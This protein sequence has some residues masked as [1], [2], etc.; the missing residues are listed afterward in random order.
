MSPR[1]D[2]YLSMCLEQ[3]SKSP[4][5]YR[6]GCIIVRG[7]KVIGQGYN[8]YRPGFNGGALKTGR[9]ASASSAHGF[10]ITELKQRKKS[11]TK[12]DPKSKNQE[13]TGT[14]TPFEEPA[15]GGGGHLANTP[16]S[17][18]SEMM[19]I[20][21]A[22][23]LSGTLASQGSARSARWLE[24]PYDYEALKPMS[25]LSVPIQ[26]S[27]RRPSNPGAPGSAKPSS[28][29]AR[30]A[31]KSRV[32]KP[33]HLNAVAKDKEEGNINEA[34]DKEKAREKGKRDEKAVL[35]LDSVEKYRVQ[36]AYGYHH[37]DQY[38]GRHHPHGQKAQPQQQAPKITENEMTC[39]KASIVSGTSASSSSDEGALER[40]PKKS[41]RAKI[42]KPA[43][44]TINHSAR[45]KDSLDRQHLKIAQT[46]LLPQG[47]TGSRSRSVIERT[48]DQRL[49]GADL[50]VARLGWKKDS[51]PPDATS[52]TKTQNNLNLTT[53][54]SP[55]TTPANSAPLPASPPPPTSTGSLHEEL[56][57]PPPTLSSPAPPKP[58]TTTTT[59][60]TTNT[61]H[62]LASISSSR[63]CYR[64]IAYMH[65]VG[66]KRVFWTNS[67]GEWDGGKV[68]D[69]VDALESGGPSAESD[70]CGT[71]GVAGNGVFVTKHEVLMLRRLMGG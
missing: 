16:L 14:F 21:S 17:M 23:S 43:A 34:N 59:T 53:G 62:P 71:K 10:A 18:H 55:S 56:K 29:V 13:V 7:G 66:I 51:P 28:A 58:P 50:Y 68:R 57:L 27:N 3:A 5:H 69:L 31:F 67:Q 42:Y 70:G 33:I 24:K 9:L 44:S 1:T 64:C 11:K 15:I 46:I 60:T 12:P 45:S 36:K 35:V 40:T 26:S 8:H 65:S 52:K 30:P 6:H 2:S 22:L 38:H 61:S 32:L 39:G 25:R 47:R 4:L 63:P 37:E 20:H 48:Q 19:A 49:K 54:T 41:S